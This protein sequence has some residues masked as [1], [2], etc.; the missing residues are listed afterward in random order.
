VTDGVVIVHPEWGIFVGVSMGLAFW[1]NL[2]CAGQDCVP[3]MPTEAEARAYVNLMK[4]KPSHEFTFHSVQA[5]KRWATIE[6]L[7]AAG[8]SAWTIPLKAAR[9]G[10]AQ[11]SA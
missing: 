2:D 10:E 4:N 3:V 7:D 11:G 5:A 6:E 1:S 8:L 9:M